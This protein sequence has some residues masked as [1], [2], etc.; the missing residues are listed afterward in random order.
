MFG[1]EAFG[2]M[3]FSS[4]FS[5]QVSLYGLAS[6][7]ITREF[8][9][10]S[11]TN[12]FVTQATDA[13]PTQP[14]F[15]TLVQP[16]SFTRSLLGADI[17][18]N[19]SSGTGE[20]QLTNT[21]GSYDFLIQG[22]A[23]DGR[24]IIVKVGREGEAYN[25]FYTIFSGTASDWSVQEDFVKLKLVDNGYLL[26]VTIQANLYAGTGSGAT[27]EGTADL[28]GKRKPRSFGY[29]KNISPPLVTPSSLLYQVNDGSVQAITAVYDRGS[30]LTFSANYATTALLK[31][32]TIA[33][34]SY[35]TCLATGFFRLNTSPTG[36]VTADISGDNR[37]S[38]FVSTS[39]DIVRRILSSSAVPDPLGLYL[40]SFASVLAAQPADIG[41]YVA[42]DSTNT[43]ADAISNI[44]GAIGGWGGFRR[45]GKFELGIFLTQKNTMP[46]AVFSRSDIISISREPLPSSLSPPPYRFR[47]AYQHNWTVQTD[48]AGSVSATQKSFLAQADRY[49][50]SLNT[51]VLL[52]H[53]FAHDRNPIASYFNTQAAA[54]AESDR[55]LALYASSAALYRMTFGIEPFGLDLGD[56]MNVTYPRWDMTVGRNLRIVEITENAQS[57]TIEVVGYG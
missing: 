20:L 39:S 7:S 6:V 15:G 8:R 48:V 19:F 31:A 55:L 54:Q 32:A 52:D 21:D 23:I 44:M 1:S 35:A 46:N 25:N 50:N 34:G 45:S 17:I 26:D 18:G 36:T 16:L 24:S 9:I 4:T 29:V 38:G 40:P 49:S 56:I 53:P 13:I 22:F 5:A 47:C 33:A 41:Y 10:F 57:N 27:E 12:E 42:P 30:P 28:L 51:T 11:A 37:G 3:A 43:I 2:E 14:F